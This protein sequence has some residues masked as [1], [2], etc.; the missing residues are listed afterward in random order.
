MSEKLCRISLK[1]LQ[2]TIK[3][4]ADFFPVVEK[5]AVGNK[6]DQQ[7]C[8]LS[9]IYLIRDTP[10]V[11]REYSEILWLGIGWAIENFWRRTF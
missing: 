1:K 2:M 8:L 3:Y 11:I 10:Y 5:L 9:R 6:N 4:H 7:L